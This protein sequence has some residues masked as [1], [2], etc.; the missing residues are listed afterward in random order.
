MGDLIEGGGGYL[1]FWLRGRSLLKRGL[2]RAFT[3]YRHVI[4]PGKI[5]IKGIVRN[6]WMSQKSLFLLAGCEIERMRPMFKTNK[7]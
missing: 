2:N 4:D 7:C 5:Q 3:V 6:Y 1:K